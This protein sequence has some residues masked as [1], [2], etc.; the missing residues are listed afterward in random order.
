M[1]A[2]ALRKRRVRPCGARRRP[3]GS[4][5][6]P[7]AVAEMSRLKRT[8]RPGGQEL[9]NYGLNLPSIPSSLPLPM[10]L[11][12]MIFISDTIFPFLVSQ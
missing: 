5:R 8:A 9:A 1:E 3:A 11:E 12:A 4:P 2:A 7:K 10:M 6:S